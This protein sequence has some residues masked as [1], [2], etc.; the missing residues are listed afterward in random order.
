MNNFI[1]N[2]AFVLGTSFF[3]FFVFANSI[4]AQNA[5]LFIHPSSGTYSTNEPF[6]VEIRMD[7]GGKSVGTANAT[8]VYDQNDV[9]FVSVSDE[10]SIFSTILVDSTR[11]TGKID[12][13]GLIGKG[14][15]AFAGSDGLFAKITFIPLRNTTAQFHFESGAATTPLSPLGA[16]VGSLQNILSSLQIASYTFIPKQTVQGANVIYTSSAHAEETFGITPLP[17]PEYEWFGTSTITLN[18]TLPEGVTEMR[19]L[20]SQNPHDTPSKLYTTPM[21]SITLSDLSDGEQYFL[22]QFKIHD[23]WGSVISYPLK[24]DLTEPSEIAIKETERED[25]SDPRVTFAVESVDEQSGILKY[26]M[27]IDG[28]EPEVWEKKEGELYE[29][30]DLVIGEHVLTATA[31]D[32]AGNVSSSTDVVF[33]VQSLEAPILNNESI[34]DRVLT[35]DMITVSGTTY[36]NAE[37]TVFISHNNGDASEKKVTSDGNGNFTVT[38]TEGARTGKYTLWFSVKDERGA[39]S[40]NSIKRS[41]EVSQ[42]YIMLFGTQAVTYLSVI[43]PLV[44][45]IGVL[46]LIVWLAFTWIRSYRKRIKLETNEAYVT[47]HEE[48]AKL[49]NELIHQIGMLE[50]AN[51]SRELTREEMRIFTDLS[52]RLDKMEEHISQEIED[53]ESV[54]IKE[55]H[56]LKNKQVQGSLEKYRKKIQVTT[57]ADEGHVVRL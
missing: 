43:V 42:P 11:E 6:T 47:T 5:S 33:L 45:L 3:L 7:T 39:M 21:S 8:L 48:F 57:R 13:S 27:S 25:V 12:I 4:F 41:I 22:L 46:A 18:W 35:G 32:R 56:L 1:K 17:V 14:K 55:K 53:V 19:T 51:Q 10:G 15:E 16:S 2:S 36:P 26:E 28:S 30:K 31:Y 54:E 44:A 20:I 52:R 37:V 38:I 49:R 24:I 34:P 29:P 40:P 23:V 9:S 50:K